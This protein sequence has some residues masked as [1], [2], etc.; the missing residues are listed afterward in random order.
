M[1]VSRG[2]KG[3]VR[4]ADSKTTI[5]NGSAPDP[6]LTSAPIDVSTTLEKLYIIGTRDP[7]EISQGSREISGSV[8]R[9]FDGGNVAY[10]GGL[11]SLD[12]VCEIGVE[13]SSEYTIFIA[14]NGS[15][16][17][18]EFYIRG[19]R[20]GS[21]SLSITADGITTE[22]AEWVATNVSTA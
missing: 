20:F 8:E 22:S 9:N 7:D 5:T 3:V 1:G 17:A 6:K 19:A 18:P 16:N 4:I 10:Y 2:W 21:Y 11:I 12:E 13:N 15:G 14:P